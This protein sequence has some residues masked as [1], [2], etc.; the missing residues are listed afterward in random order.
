MQKL[1]AI[2]PGMTGTGIAVFNMTRK[3]IL[4]ITTRILEPDSSGRV[5]DRMLW[6][7]KRTL[8][9]LQEY[10]CNQVAIELPRY[11]PSP[12]GHTS[13]VKGNLT[14]LFCACSAVTAATFSFGASLRLVPVN[15]W[16]GT[17]PKQVVIQR[18]CKVINCDDK[19]YKSHVWD[20]IGIGLYVQ[21]FFG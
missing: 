9:L 20:A 14:T 2:D 7:Y 4:P 1:M 5:E 3:P 18:I 13:A 6:L 16:K 15:D 12:T 8:S 19:Q 21:G 11:M 17:L 10:R